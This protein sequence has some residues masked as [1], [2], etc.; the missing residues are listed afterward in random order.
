MTHMIDFKISSKH[1][2]ITLED[3]TID[4][5]LTLTKTIVGTKGPYKV[6]ISWE[7]DGTD[8]TDPEPVLASEPAPA[9][10]P[11]LLTVESTNHTSDPESEQMVESKPPG[12]VAPPITTVHESTPEPEQEQELKPGPESSLSNDDLA[13][14]NTIIRTPPDT[15][16]SSGIPHPNSTQNINKHPPVKL[17][18]TLDDKIRKNDFTTP[19][20]IPLETNLHYG[21]TEDG[22]ILIKYYAT[23]IDTIWEDLNELEQTIPNPIPRGIPLLSYH[24]SGNRRSAVIKFIEYIRIKGIKQGQ[25]IEILDKLN[26]LAEGPET[27]EKKDPVIFKELDAISR[28]KLGEYIDI[29]VFEMGYHNQGDGKIIICYGTTKVYTSWEDMFKLPT[30]IDNESIEKLDN[31]KQVAVRNFRKWMADHSDLL[32][33]GVDPDAEFRS[34]DVGNSVYPPSSPGGQDFGGLGEDLGSGE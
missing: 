14:I 18:S 28:T 2:G 27:K 22:R 25:A 34:M 32:P 4:Q 7:D 8:D 21:E 23:R 5:A 26:H 3:I 20:L 17:L 11:E 33:N 31:L 15:L 9:H 29:N 12:P 10:M 6:T 1:G 16:I 13:E 24:D 19:T 30:F